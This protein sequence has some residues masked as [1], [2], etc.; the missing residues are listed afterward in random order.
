MRLAPS[1]MR[2]SV[3]ASWLPLVV[4]LD[5]C[6]LAARN[7]DDDGLTHFLLNSC[8]LYEVRECRVIDLGQMFRVGLPLLGCGFLCGL[9]VGYAPALCGECAF[10][11]GLD[12]GLGFLG[13]RDCSHSRCFCV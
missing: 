2:L 10:G 12:G 6:D 13:P 3:L 9:G 11:F 8:H 4:D 5:I 1:Q 7:C